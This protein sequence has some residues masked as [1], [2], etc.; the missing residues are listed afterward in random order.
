L[1]SQKESHQFQLQ[2][3]QGKHLFWRKRKGQG[4]K[5]K[6]GTLKS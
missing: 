2:L 6:A 4:Q 1:G 3:K 5:E